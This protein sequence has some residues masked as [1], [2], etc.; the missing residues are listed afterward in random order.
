MSKKGG[1]SDAVWFSRFFFVL[2]LFLLGT[3]W[4]IYF[5]SYSLIKR[6]RW[7][8]DLVELREENE[9]LR[10]EITELKQRLE[11][12]PT[13][14]EIEKIAREQYGMRKEGETVYRIGQ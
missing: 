5:D 13:D 9:K 3:V 4:F 12:P 10:E 11:A 8:N 6:H 1:G 7:H 14:E 2:A